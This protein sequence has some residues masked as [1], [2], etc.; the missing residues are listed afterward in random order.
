MSFFN[1]HI[2]AMTGYL[3]GEQPEDRGIVK[4]N[5]NENPY[6]PSP[7][8]LKAI[9]ALA[10]DDLR[11]YPNSLGQSF[12][13]A[14]GSV[15]RID[16]ERII[17]GN[18]GDDLLNLAIRAFAGPGRPVVSPMP[19]Y[20]LYQVL[21]S[22]Q[23]AP[24]VDVE[25]PDDYSLPADKIVAAGGAVTFL[26]NPN[27]PS[28]TFIEIDQIANLAARLSG[29]LVVDEAYVD[30]APDDATQLAGSCENVLVFRSMSKGYGLAGLRF[31]F[32]IGPTPL[33][34]G[35]LKIKD[36]YN[37]DAVSAAAATAAITD[38][39]Y[40]RGCWTKIIAE[41]DRITRRL[42]E[43]GFHVC[44]SEA[45]FVLARWSGGS[46]RP[47][48]EALAERNVYVRHFDTKRLADCLRI[49]V[50]DR[51]QNSVFLT[52]LSEIVADLGG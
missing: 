4:L 7:E 18:G 6:P 16:P 52:E 44:P 31:G 37:V 50:G 1:Q 21:A 45:N 5:T 22:I 19:S 2:D 38:Q 36:S 25:F 15:L 51:D 20:T 49:T 9:A 33:I 43:L 3:P 29:V 12:R 28:G 13:E 8:A 26:C 27:S 47:L 17:C 11:R 32:G 35:L 24:F 41:R 48:Y 23:G 14:A 40:N 42:G 39:H 34:E 30:F 46:A 10:P